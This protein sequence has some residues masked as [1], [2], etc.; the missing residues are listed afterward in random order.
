MTTIT[1]FAFNPFYENTYIISN[2]EGECWIIDPGCYTDAER[3]KLTDH[4]SVNKLTPTKLLNTHC[5]LDHIFGN[6]FI[7]DTYHLSPQWHEAET[8]IAQNSKISAMMFGVKPPEY[9]EPGEMLVPGETLQL[10]NES[11][12]MLFT[13]G[14]S[15]G[16]I[17][18]YNERE[19]YAI[20]G[21]V[22]FRESIGRTDLPG[23]NYDTLIKSIKKELLT[24]P[25]DVVI[26]NG[27][28]PSTTIGHERKYNSFLR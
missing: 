16:S 11:F 14:H 22:L 3:K 17:T 4:I 12:K 1:S 13:P 15:P 20:A 7:A 2:E 24:L 25:D 8:F 5:H 26:Y 6:A 19:K 27:H 10:G 23:G 9:R 18:F 28:G 21:D